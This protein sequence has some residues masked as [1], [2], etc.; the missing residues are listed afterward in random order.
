MRDFVYHNPV[1]I[2]FG[3]QKLALLPTEI[4]SLGQ[5]P[6]IVCGQRHLFESATFERICALLQASG[7][8]YHLFSG[9]Q[10]NPVLSKVH[11]GIAQYRQQQCDCIIA[12]GGGSVIDTAKAISVGSVHDYNVWKLFL[13]KKTIRQTVP[14]IAIP[15]TAGSG[16]EV[17][18]GMVIT[19]DRHNLKLGYGH[20]LLFPRVCIADPCLTVTLPQK[21]TTDGVIDAFVHCLEPYLSHQS[22]QARFQPR[23]L[24]LLIKMILNTG[25][26]LIKDPQ[27]Y[28]LRAEML[29]MSG[30]A[31]SGIST[32][33]LGR[34]QFELHLLEHS[35]SAL[36]ST[37]S[38]GDG[39]AA[40]LP[41]WLNGNADRLTTRLNCLSNYLSQATDNPVRLS[42]HPVAYFKKILATLN[43]PQSLTDLGIVKKDIPQLVAH[44]QLQARIWKMKQCSS[45]DY[46]A[47]LFNTCL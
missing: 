25:I 33:G 7:I 38:H 15:T 18:N 30:L 43:A 28:S 36:D 3:E 44:C 32:S 9:V 14:V 2:L 26:S 29:W 4:G 47:S 46:L 31:M 20:R 39:L 23:F 8:T 21:L 35:L 27:S 10:A 12:I 5:K 11:A 42:T 22:P 16:S 24:E 41:G 6:L 45:S 17:N 37:I 13:G 34:L 1:K 19:D 40:L